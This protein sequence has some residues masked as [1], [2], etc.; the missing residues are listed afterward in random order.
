MRFILIILFLFFIGCSQKELAPVL[1]FDQ[2]ISAL[3]QAQEITTQELSVFSQEFIQKHFSPWMQNNLK[4][5]ENTATWGYRLFTKDKNYVGENLLEIDALWYDEIKTLSNFEQFGTILK[6]A[7]TIKNTNLRVFPASKPLYKKA[8]VIGVGYPFDLLQSSFIPIMTPVFISHYSQD[9]SWAYIESSYASGWIKATDLA[10][11]SNEII[12]IFP[13]MYFLTTVVEKTPLYANKKFV[14]YLKIGTILALKGEDDLFYYV[15]LVDSKGDIYEGN[16]EKKYMSYFPVDFNDKNVK[17]ILGGLI[18][19]KYGWGGLYENRDC[20]ATTKDFFSVFGIW[21]PRNS[22]A[23]KDEGVTVDISKY[24]NEEKESV[25]KKHAIPYRSL[26]YLPGHIMLYIGEID[27]K[28][29][30]FHNIWGLRI[31]DDGTMGR[32]IF[33]RTIISDLKIGENIENTVKNSLLIDRITSFNILASKESII[34][35]RLRL[36]Y[37]DF[38][39]HVKNNT[40]YFKNNSTLILDDKIEKTFD[41]MIDNADIKDM[42]SQKYQKGKQEHYP[43]QDPGR[44]RNY[45]FFD[46]IYG[47]T[48]TEIESNLAEVVWLPK[49]LNIKLMFNSKNGAAKALQKVSNE[50][51]NLPDEFLK[52]L[53]NPAGTYNYRKISNTNRLSMHSY[54]IAIDINAKLSNYWLWDNGQYIYINSIPQEIV[55][56]FEKYGFIW[57]GKWYHYDT[58]HFEFRPELL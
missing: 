32:H 19:E 8:T 25:I 36:S 43:L 11:V 42:F 44:I 50:L 28:V 22:F 6:K 20:S 29:A 33:G 51:D 21:L 58:M 3:P 46:T 30:V 24:S 10:H 15:Y 17:N 23:Q 57:G 14:S 26:I 12:E 7:I 2:N 56:I 5:S 48:K 54:G 39:L 1:I 53:I 49:K 18:G 41:E 37:P 35:A 13:K 16:V 31:I 45:D 47:K 38:I 9:Y 55:D 52:Y 27:K 40:V 34:G 4:V